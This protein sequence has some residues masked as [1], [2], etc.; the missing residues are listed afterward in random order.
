MI[1]IECNHEDEG[2]VLHIDWR[3]C[4]QNTW[5][6]WRD[7][8]KIT[9]AANREY[10]CVSDQIKILSAIGRGG[11]I[12]V[13]RELAEQWLLLKISRPRNEFATDKVT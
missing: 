1:W 9:A 2:K 11:A 10:T 8:S 13:M 4:D 3:Y 12:R 5:D 7:E 6:P